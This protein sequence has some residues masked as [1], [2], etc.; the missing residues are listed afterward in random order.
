MLLLK[1]A[2]QLRLPANQ[3][4]HGLLMHSRSLHLGAV[5]TLP[6]PHRFLRVRTAFQAGQISQP[7]PMCPFLR[8][9][10][11]IDLVKFVMTGETRRRL[12]MREISESHAI[13]ETQ[14]RRGI[15]ESLSLL[16]KLGITARQRR[17]GPRDRESFQQLID[18]C[19]ML[20]YGNQYGPLSGIGRIEQSRRLD[21]LIT[22]QPQTGKAA[23]QEIGPKGALIPD[24]QGSLPLRH[25]HQHLSRRTRSTSLLSIQ[26]A[27][28][29]LRPTGPISSTQLGLRS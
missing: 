19:R 17:H 20:L 7:G 14:R 16:G 15:P 10:M 2:P 24:R 8:E 25:L 9:S 1:E 4:R 12:E 13:P 22:R 23:R 3:S 28:G 21:G 6:S 11:Q 18:A 5:P 29:S 27:R 26:S